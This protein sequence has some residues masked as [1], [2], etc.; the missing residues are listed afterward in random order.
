[1]GVQRKTKVEWYVMDRQGWFSSCFGQLGLD[2]AVGGAIE[3][4]SAVEDGAVGREGGFPSPPSAVRRYPWW[5]LVISIMQC[6][7]CAVVSKF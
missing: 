5:W 2:A 4:A 3:G 6:Y 1:M 7:Y